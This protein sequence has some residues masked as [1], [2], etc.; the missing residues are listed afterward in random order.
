MI[1]L[2]WLI[3]IG[4]PLLIAFILLEGRR[5]ERKYGRGS[6]TGA[7]LMRAGALEMQALLEPEKKVEVLKQEKEDHALEAFSGDTPEPS[8][9]GPKS[10]GGRR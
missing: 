4:V 7:R 6:G 9:P 3:L 2:R 8:G 1:P 10:E 5:Q